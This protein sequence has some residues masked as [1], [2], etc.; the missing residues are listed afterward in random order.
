MSPLC[1]LS[2]LYCSFCSGG[3]GGDCFDC[4]GLFN[5]VGIMAM[6]EIE[7]TWEQMALR[8]F[9]L[10]L[11][12]CTLLPL[13]NKGTHGASFSTSSSSSR[14]SSSASSDFEEEECHRKRRRFQRDSRLL[15]TTSF[16]A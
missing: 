9:E 7:L 16:R 5:R 4:I 10:R 11:L 13:H 1:E 12:R 8:I 2:S 6:M 3:G 14:S 15:E